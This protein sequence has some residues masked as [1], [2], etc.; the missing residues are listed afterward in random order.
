MKNELSNITAN[1]EIP[2]K[3]AHAYSDIVA[4]VNAAQNAIKSA[5]Q[6]AGNATELVIKLF[7]HFKIHK[8]YLNKTTLLYISDNWH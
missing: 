2:L 5:K 6:A 1:S 7:K 3:A 4:D 8:L